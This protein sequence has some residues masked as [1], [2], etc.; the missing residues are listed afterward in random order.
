MDLHRQVLAAAERAADARQRQPDL[1]RRQAEALGEL[2]AVDVQPLGR[3]VEVDA[4]LAVGHREP[5]LGA[6]ER[7]VLHPDLVLAG[8]DDVGGR[9]GVAVV[10]ADVAQDV[11]AEVHARRVGRHRRA[12]GR[13]PASSTSYSTAI[14]AAARRAVSGW[15]A[16]TI[17]TGS[18]W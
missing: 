14:A 3:D 18:P 11:A 15:S 16:A 7:L 10:D 12:R 9:V 4:A 17:A 13:S 2:V 6:E 1:L 5:G 8:D